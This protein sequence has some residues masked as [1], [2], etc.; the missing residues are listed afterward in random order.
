MD[1]PETRHI[2]NR[3]ESM[4]GKIAQLRQAVSLLTVENRALRNALHEDTGQD[5]LSDERDGLIER[6]LAVISDDVPPIY[7][8]EQLSPDL[9]D[10]DTNDLVGETNKDNTD[11]QDDFSL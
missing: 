11:D 3:I 5:L 7:R 4:E 9:N 10:G 1:D 2:R 6:P 8:D